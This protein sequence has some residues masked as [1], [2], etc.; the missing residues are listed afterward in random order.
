MQYV[1]KPRE[2]ITLRHNKQTPS[3]VSV[4]VQS[5]TRSGGRR[6]IYGSSTPAGVHPLFAEIAFD[7]RP[8]VPYVK[9]GMVVVSMYEMV[10]MCRTWVGTPTYRRVEVE[11]NVSLV[12][13][14]ISS[15]NSRVKPV[16]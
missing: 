3:A 7:D 15:G 5:T 9:H 8:Q 1:C 14:K 4:C 13:A 12:V 11:N 2:Q 10:Q 16:K 6:D